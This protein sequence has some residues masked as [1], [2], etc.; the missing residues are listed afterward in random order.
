MVLSEW[1]LAMI[2]MFPKIDREKQL[3]FADVY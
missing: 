2:V 1:S 3:I